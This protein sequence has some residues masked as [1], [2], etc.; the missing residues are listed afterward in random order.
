MT[1]LRTTLLA[2]V[3]GGFFLSPAHAQTVVY[4]NTGVATPVVAAPVVMTPAG[5]SAVSFKADA[6][7]GAVS[8][9]SN[10]YLAPPALRTE[11]V[12]TARVGYTWAPGYWQWSN[13]QYVWV[14]GRWIESRP[15]YVWVGETWE[16]RDEGWRFAPGYWRADS[17]G[18]VYR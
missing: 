1:S 13:G 5:A 7:G 4:T 12:P 14:G 10:V 3:V 9:A 15:G 17:D 6:D 16:S 2:T 8:H 18:V 11:V